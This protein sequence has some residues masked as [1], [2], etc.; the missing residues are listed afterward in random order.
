MEEDQGVQVGPGRGSAWRLVWGPRLCLGSDSGIPALS[1]AH[2]ALLS[3]SP[4]PQLPVDTF[5][6]C[7]PHTRELTAM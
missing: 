1:L 3:P 5:P 2:T 6:C 7:V 4:L